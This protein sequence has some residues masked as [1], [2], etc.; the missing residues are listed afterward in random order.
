[1][2]AVTSPVWAATYGPDGQRQER[3]Y[4]GNNG[5]AAAQRDRPSTTPAASLPRPSAP[6]VAHNDRD[7]GDYRFHSRRYDDRRFERGRDRDFE[8][9]YEGR[10]RHYYGFERYGRGFRPWWFSRGW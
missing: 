9:R 2:A 10:H 3:S 4:N 8:R 7:N 5:A 6:V 1:M